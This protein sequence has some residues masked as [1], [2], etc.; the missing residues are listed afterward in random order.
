MLRE[1]RIENLILVESARIEF[2][3]GFN[4]LTGETGSGKSAVMGAL[5]LIV[6]ERADPQWIRRGAAKGVVEALFD[7]PGDSPVADIL[8][9]AGIPVDEAGLVIRREVG[10]RSRAFVNN[11]VATLHLL[12]ALQPHL[13]HLVDQHAN[14]SLLAKDAH[15]ALVDI[16]GD[17]APLLT[18]FRCALEME[19]ALVGELAELKGREAERIRELGVCRMEVAELEE[20]NLQEGE[21][22]EL[23]Q[24]FSVLSNAETLAALSKQL[25]GI[26]SATL[27]QLRNAR[28]PLAQLAELDPS[29]EELRKSVESVALELEE[30]GYTL[31]NYGTGLNFNRDRLSFLDERLALINRM[32]RKYGE[33]LEAIE[34]YQQ[35]RQARVEELESA[36]DRI[37]EL[38]ESLQGVRQATEEA[39]AAL[40][41]RRTSAALELQE[42]LTAEVRPLN[43]PNAELRIAVSTVARSIKGDDQV[44]FQLAPN[45]GERFV[46]LG[47]G[48]SGGEI[49][50]VMLALKTVLAGKEQVGTLV[51]DELDA[52][53][54]GET[55]SVVGE[56]LAA[57][58][59]K[60]QLL[61]ITHFAQVA[62][63]AGHHLRICKEEQE[64]RT[65]T[66]VVP[67]DR[68][69]R[70]QELV[71]ML[72]GASFTT[73]T[74]RL[75]ETV[76][77]A[78]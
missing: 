25:T 4:V 5:R 13:I 64:G 34:R 31:R 7:T 32:K 71:R 30:V 46:A 20:A 1:L 62:A 10:I 67:L 74:K 69:T 23:F 65:C 29:Q 68:A 61:C 56:K 70:E 2:E 77:G 60:H 21:E 41:E 72:G 40:T 52:N 55:A 15:R 22:E 18:D 6:G 54:G 49:A 48:V 16:Y 27:S 63:S 28:G 78:I 51:F 66:L 11:Q 8:E 44:T 42:Q 39:A 14:H 19:K 36:D 12:K 26:T 45:V 33:S 57:I 53:I 35:N 73:E 37:E 43:M 3:S 59:E 38:E 24:E 9:G 17:C 58:S 47:E 75:A 50:R 76:C